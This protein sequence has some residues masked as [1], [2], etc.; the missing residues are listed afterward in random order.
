MFSVRR[1]RG[2]TV[3]AARLEA[4]PGVVS[5][6]GVEVVAG[7]R[8]CVEQGTRGQR[9]QRRETGAR[10]AHG[11][12]V[13]EASPESGQP[14]E[15]PALMV[16]QQTPRVLDGGPQAALARGGVPRTAEQVV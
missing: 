14:G 15:R 16:A 8:G 12:L 2:S 3:L 4:F 13:G 11:G 10:H 5:D 7:V 6:Q 9:A 1:Q